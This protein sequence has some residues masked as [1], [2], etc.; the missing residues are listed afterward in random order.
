MPPLQKLMKFTT[1]FTKEETGRT[2]FLLLTTLL[3]L[4]ASL[5]ATTP[6][7]P[8]WIRIPAS[9]LTGLGMIRFFMF[10]HDHLHGALFSNSPLGKAIMWCY[11]VF[12]LTPP[13]IWRRSHN[14]HHRCNAQIATASIG[15]FPVMT[16]KQYRKAS[17]SKKFLYKLARHPLIFL[18]SYISVFL[19]G[20][21]LKSFKENPKKHWDSL[22]AILVHISLLSFLWIVFGPSVTLL[23]L[24]VP[25]IVTTTIGSYLFYVQHNYPGVKMKK[26]EDW[27]YVFA[28]LQSSSLLAGGP[29]LHWF[30]GNIGLHHV[31]HLNS[32][33]PFYR[34]PE[35]MAAIPELQKNPDTSL[36]PR[37][38]IQCLKLKL[39][40][41]EKDELVEFSKA[42]IY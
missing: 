37:D 8:L 14:Y 1:P 4:L 26:R 42:Q 23:C 10:Y 25:F 13:N 3:F 15:S 40:D 12:L 31:H 11:G 2:W 32:S 21:C 20:M 30:T 38:I 27:S 7:F 24:I 9:L 39:W 35:A 41:P 17:P 29:L 16:I 22:L 6:L 28:A 33:I 34:L 19:I 5:F 18:T 36:S